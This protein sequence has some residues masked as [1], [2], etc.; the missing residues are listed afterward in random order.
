M[1]SACWRALLAVSLIYMTQAEGGEWAIVGARALG[2]GGANVAVANDATAS[3]WNPGAFGLFSATSY[4][5]YGKRAWSVQPADAGAGA[6]L[7]HDFGERLND[8]ARYDYG[9]VSGGQIQAQD[10]PD[11]VGLL[12]AVD[13]FNADKKRAATIHVD[14]ALGVQVGRFGVGALLL[15]SL[16]AMGRMDVIN[17][18]PAGSGT[19]SLIA[20]FSDASNFNGGNPIPSGGPFYFTSPQEDSLITQ[21]SQ[22][23]GWD[24]A[25]ATNFVR[26]IDYGLSKANG[27]TIPSDIASQVITAAKMASD[28]GSG[29]SFKDNGSQLLFKGVSL[30]E[31]PLTYG[32]PVTEDLAIGG[33]VKVMK[34]RVY[35]VAVRAFDTKLK[36]AASEARKTYEESEAFGVDLGLLYRFGDDL[37]VGLVGRNL[38]SPRFKSPASADL[39]ER[40]QVRAG[41]AYKPVGFVML[42]ADAD[43]TRNETAVG[44]FESQNVGV[45]LEINLIK[46]LNLRAGA[47]KNIADSDIGLVYTAGLGL[48]MWLLNLDLGASFASKSAKFDN[49]NIPE[50]ARAELSL[51]M[52]F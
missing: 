45:G 18:A 3:Y 40:P 50:E 34:A 27:S 22:M 37:R 4:D 39:T 33:N 13:S 35:D 7:R 52:L 36:D 20:Q 51:S 25:S 11:F 48:N 26:A 32:V 23:P 21:I 5:D 12:N 17:I 8:I 6:R 30:A 9:R 44:G 28:A 49:N 14:G 24:N 15:G 47:Y 16:S 1:K 19:G 42:A 31:I 10:V 38:N 46:A 43:L 2:M 41:V 29:G